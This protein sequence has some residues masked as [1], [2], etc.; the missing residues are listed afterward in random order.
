MEK[1]REPV[2]AGAFYPETKSQLVKMLEKFTEP[3][4]EKTDAISVICPHAGYVYSGP[5]A[6]A[7]Y[8]G[9]TIP[10]TVVILG[11]NHTG[12][13]Q[14]YA[15]ANHNNWQTP[16]GEVELNREIIKKLVEKSKYLEADEVAHEEEH[17][18][19]V[20]VPFLQFFKNNVKIVPVSLSGFLNDPAWAEIGKVLADVIQESKKE[21]LIVASTDMTHYEDQKS[22]ESKDRYAIEAILSL[23]EDQLIERVSEKDISMCGY[24]PVIVSI[25]ASK[26]LGAKKGTLV[27]YATSGDVSGNYDR[28]VGYAGIIIQ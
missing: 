7:V 8:K 25:I 27:R 13:G 4:A 11:P 2:V 19:E 15:V 1:G 21:V 24:G 22:A 23:N 20:Q 5:T 16:L 18:I 3:A 28:V 10:E 14:P 26:H 12:H 17:S 9:I 6:G